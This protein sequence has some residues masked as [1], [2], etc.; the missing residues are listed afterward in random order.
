MFS[1]KINMIMTTDHMTA[2]HENV[3]KKKHSAKFTQD[4]LSIH[5]C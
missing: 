3:G 5:D 4:A 2:N 1:S